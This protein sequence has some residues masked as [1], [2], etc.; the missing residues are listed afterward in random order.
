MIQGQVLNKIL[1]DKDSSIITLNNLTDDYFSD[2]KDEFNFI[3]NHIN[4][5]SIVPDK[6][7]FLDRFPDFPLF[8]VNEPTNYLLAELLEDKKKRTIASNYNDVRTL[9]MNGKIDE[10]M[11]KIQD[12]ANSNASLV[13]LEAVDILND[14]SRYDDYVERIDNSDKYFIKT[15]FPELDK[16]IGGWDA[17]DELATI[18]ARNGLGK[19]WV[20][21]KA[22]AA[23]AQQGKRVGIYS[24]EMS[25]NKVGY[26]IDSILGNISNGALIHGSGSVKNE[27]K[28]FLE[29]LPEKVKGNIFVTT[30]KMINGPAGVGALRTFIEKY[31]LDVLFI[32]QHS[33]LEDDRKAKNPVEKA[34]N[35]SKDLKLLQ[36]I[37]RIPIISVCQQN[38]SKIEDEDKM[39]DTTQLAQSDRIA[40]DSTLIIFIERKDDLMKLHLVKSRDTENGKIITYRVDLN[41]GI[42]TYVPDEDSDD[43]SEDG[44][45]ETSGYSEDD[46]DVF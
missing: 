11:V 38:R 32:D 27:Y 17:Q 26:R 7:T 1:N 8:E 28:Q 25:E 29:D 20:L 4:Q 40:Q 43:G 41:R 14:T 35:I 12:L 37:K 46:L 19:T 36:V 22:A 30:P 6:E 34:S 33:L 5:C 18:V 2:Y 24:G 44:N 45:I 15:G 23:A 39:F 21:L 9:L 3:K 10:A 13:S 16:I 31:K 42:W